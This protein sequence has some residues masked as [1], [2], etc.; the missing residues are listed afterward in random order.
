MC[1]ASEQESG[2]KLSMLAQ[3]AGSFA[4]PAALQD[5]DARSFGWRLHRR[6]RMRL[7]H[8]LQGTPWL[9]LPAIW[10]YMMP[11]QLDFTTKSVI[12]QGLVISVNCSLALS[13]SKRA[14]YTVMPLRHDQHLAEVG[15]HA[16]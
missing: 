7:Q 11:L 15:S 9:S 6:H 3:N 8:N 12:A 1:G 14:E 2:P 16:A 13:G 5:V 4:A 10:H